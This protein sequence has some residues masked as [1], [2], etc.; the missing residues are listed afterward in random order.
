MKFL[1]P[2]LFVAMSL[3]VNAQPR[4]IDTFPVEIN[5][6]CRNG[7]AQHYDECSDQTAILY[8]A[9][10]KANATDKSVLIV[11]GA[12]WCIWCHVF[13]K[14]IQGTNKHFDY[15]WEQNGYA[16]EWKMQEATDATTPKQAL[17]L[18]HY[19][20]SNFVVAY[21]EGH[22]APK[23]GAA[24]ASIGVNPDAV[25][26]YPFFFVLDQQGQY[27]GHMRAYNAIEGL[28]LR[29]SAGKNYRGFDRKILLEQ[30]ANLREQAKQANAKMVSS[31]Q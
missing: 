17:A 31:D 5:S 21:I 20:A 19:V 14:H 13:D 7:V 28:E 3:Q 6:Q 30:L 10:E 1:L 12:E 25:Q 8:S 23:G 11:F 2:L 24:I 4:K 16:R 18:N 29:E 27:A 26:T 9:I 22:Y 15:Q